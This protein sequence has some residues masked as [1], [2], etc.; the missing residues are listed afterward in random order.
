M[1]SENEFDESFE[2]TS[3][4][5]INKYHIIQMSFISK[6]RPLEMPNLNPSMFDLRVHPCVSA[7]I[8]T[9]TSTSMLLVA[10]RRIAAPI[11]IAYNEP[12]PNDEAPMN[13]PS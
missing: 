13:K 4:E 9:K 7:K 6:L 2:D 11:V 5:A 3:E 1:K 8:K 10:E 12:K